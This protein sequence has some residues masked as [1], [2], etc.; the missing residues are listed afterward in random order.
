[1]LGK[2]KREREADLQGAAIGGFPMQTT[3]FWGWRSRATQQITLGAAF[4]YLA[5]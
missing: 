5:F 3:P 4:C 1:M 2:A